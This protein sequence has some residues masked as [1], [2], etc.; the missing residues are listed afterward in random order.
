MCAGGGGRL[1]SAGPRGQK[2]CSAAGEPT[3]GTGAGAESW[4]PGEF[5][6]GQQQ[7]WCRRGGTGQLDV[8]WD[9]NGSEKGSAQM[10]CRRRALPWPE[11]LGVLGDGG[12]G[13]GAPLP[14]PA[15]QPSSPRRPPVAALHPT[16]VAVTC[17]PDARSGAG[18]LGT[19]N[20]DLVPDLC[21]E[22]TS[23]MCPEVRTSQRAAFLWLRVSRRGLVGAV[24]GHLPGWVKATK[25]SRDSAGLCSQSAMVPGPRETRRRG[26]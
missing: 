10:I 8:N 4:K 26:P 5:R 17:K 15:E 20:G 12:T 7:T 24:F 22:S 19:V 6:A 21:Q 25:M 3:P 11:Q 2:T 23:S 14:R 1:A 13:M 18:D 9:V 16:V